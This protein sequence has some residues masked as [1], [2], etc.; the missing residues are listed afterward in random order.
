MRKAKLYIGDELVDADV[1]VE[2]NITDKGGFDLKIPDGPMECTFRLTGMASPDAWARLQRAVEDAVNPAAK[3]WRRVF[4][5][6]SGAVRP[7]E[8]VD[9]FK[10]WWTAGSF[11]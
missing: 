4:T 1:D 9:V 5:T 2:I 10:P 7:L 3:I 8:P 11:R 6:P